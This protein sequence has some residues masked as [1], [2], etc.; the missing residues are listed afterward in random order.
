MEAALLAFGGLL[1]LSW[2]ALLAWCVA[3]V[4]GLGDVAAP[5]AIN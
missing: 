5:T 2:C 4:F 1:T 3:R